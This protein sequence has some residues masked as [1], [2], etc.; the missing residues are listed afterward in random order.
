MNNNF[1]IIYVASYNN[2]MHQTR[3]LIVNFKNSLEFYSIKKGKYLAT[4]ILA[5]TSGGYR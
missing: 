1:G 4:K 2:D 3:K 5:N